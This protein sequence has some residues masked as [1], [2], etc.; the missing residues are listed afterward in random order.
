MPSLSTVW[1]KLVFRTCFGKDRLSDDELLDD[2]FV[3][4]PC[5]PNEGNDD[6]W[7]DGLLKAENDWW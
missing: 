5:N 6:G 7:N 3:A 1:S 2:V 4:N